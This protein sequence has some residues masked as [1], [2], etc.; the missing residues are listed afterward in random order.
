MR[1]SLPLISIAELHVFVRGGMSEDREQKNRAF[2]KCIVNCEELPF[3][4]RTVALINDGGCSAFASLDD[5][6]RNASVSFVL[7]R[8]SAQTGRKKTQT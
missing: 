2:S 3:R 8:L 5:L 1:Q 4:H 6:L 7:H